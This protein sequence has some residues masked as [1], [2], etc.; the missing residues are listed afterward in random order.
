MTSA[1][2]V[3]V[4]YTVEVATVSLVTVTSTS[5]VVVAVWYAISVV[6]AVAYFVDVT[7]TSLVDVA[8]AYLRKC[9]RK[10]H[11]R[12]KSRLHTWSRCSTQLK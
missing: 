2:F 5:L 12:L 7:S 8:V 6:Y 3:E 4:T 1:A 11:R 10:A 9:Q